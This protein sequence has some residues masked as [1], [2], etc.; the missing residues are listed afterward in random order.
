MGWL[1]NS[2][3]NSKLLF[4]SSIAHI[5]P[6]QCSLLSER[7]SFVRKMFIVRPLT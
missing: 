7:C 3:H 6:Q 1:E 5:K 4:T 2:R